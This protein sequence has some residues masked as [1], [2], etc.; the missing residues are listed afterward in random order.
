VEIDGP[1]GEVPVL[2]ATLLS[3]HPKVFLENTTGQRRVKG[4]KVEET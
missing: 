3:R 2:L 1:E 4:G